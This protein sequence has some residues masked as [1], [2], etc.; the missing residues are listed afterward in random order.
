[1]FLSVVMID[2]GNLR[3]QIFSRT[4]FAPSVVGTG[5]LLYFIVYRKEENSLKLDY[6]VL[7]KHLMR[8]GVGVASDSEREWRH[9]PRTTCP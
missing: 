9:P 7:H 2:W 4:G 6:T 5:F 1:M 8:Q 3:G